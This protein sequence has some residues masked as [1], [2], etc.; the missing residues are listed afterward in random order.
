MADWVPGGVPASIRLDAWWLS[1]EADPDILR[2]G[3][4]RPATGTGPGMTTGAGP[5]RP[6]RVAALLALVASADLLFFGQPRGLSVALFALLLGGVAL[7]LIPQ[8]TARAR[9]RSLLV[10]GVALLPV[11]ELWQPLSAG[12]LL[13]GLI[14]APL[15]AL[16]GQPA[17]RGLIRA[18]TRFLHRLPLLGLRDLWRFA[19][20]TPATLPDG[21][22][23]G[24]R[25][26]WG[27]PIAAGLGFALMLAGSN[28]VIET[29]VGRLVQA[30]VDLGPL[31]RRAG[32]WLVVAA[33]C[34]PFLRLAVDAATLS[35]PYGLSLDRALPGWGRLG[36]NARSVANSLVLFNLIFA[37][38]TGLDLT[39]LWGG[40]ALPDGMSHAT[41]AH[42]GAYPLVATALMAGGFALVAR[43]FADGMPGLRWLLLLWI[44][45]N[46]LLVVSSLYRLEFYV[47]AYGLTYLRLH[48]A[49]W[50]ALVAAGLG[51]TLWQ[52]RAG[53]GNGWLMLRA[54]GLGVAVL[55][56]AA[57]VNFADIIARVN[58][59]RG[60][61]PAPMAQ[62]AYRTDT[63][64]LCSLGTG[65]AA[66]IRAHELATGQR[67]CPP[68]QPAAEPEPAGWRDWGFREAR[69]RAYLT[70]N[71]LPMP[72][73]LP[74]P[75]PQS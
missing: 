64:Y 23:G 58:L 8:V 5:R 54:A 59:S 22:R 1:V 34:W 14:L 52:V 36:V 2:E 19:R 69:I 66:A 10:L 40:A 6:W 46:L 49:I 53:K 75:E 12:F 4:S 29:W 70:A 67:V 16:P 30:Q 26:A 7:A 33:V 55:Y 20:Q 24:F 11:I 48:A 44:G 42:R 62:S 61:T 68:W 3:T 25:Q 15:L 51:L 35:R 41:Y 38:Q 28:P 72:L 71:P 74:M 37:V 43:P 47:A 9:G 65:A 73:P 27:F 13:A 60:L 63:G 45:Q 50:M 17:G 21:W 32:F 56:A 18:V 57:F 31:M 39:Y